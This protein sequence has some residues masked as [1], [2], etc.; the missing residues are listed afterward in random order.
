MSVFSKDHLKVLLAAKSCLVSF[1]VLDELVCSEQ[2][3]TGYYFC[4]LFF[5]Y[6]YLCALAEKS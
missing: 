5:C 2:L 6:C 3:V 4:H 1:S